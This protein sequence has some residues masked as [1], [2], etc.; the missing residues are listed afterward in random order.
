MAQTQ[1]EFSPLNAADICRIIEVSAKNGVSEFSIDDIHFKFGPKPESVAKR[2]KQPAP[3]P[4]A[5]TSMPD[6]EKLTEEALVADS[7]FRQ[8]LLFDELTLLDPYAAEQM[9]AKGEIVDGKPN[10]DGSEQED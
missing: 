6:H 3:R 4:E 8:E 1:P 9:Y 2:Y 5:A 7:N 10:G